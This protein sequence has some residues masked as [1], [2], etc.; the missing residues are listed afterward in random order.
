ME[1]READR[2]V[3]VNSCRAFQELKDRSPL[4]EVEWQRFRAQIIECGLK[5][6]PFDE[7]SYIYPLQIPSKPRVQLLQESPRT[8]SVLGI[9]DRSNC[10]GI[11]GDSELESYYL[12]HIGAFI[13]VVGKL[14]K[15]KKNDKEY[16][17]LRPRGWLIVQVNASDEHVEKKAPRQKK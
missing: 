9:Y 15:C 16:L 12:T 7:V 17:N 8:I 3:I 2:V 6:L 4:T 11:I 5:G 13:Y 14:D 10:V 1:E